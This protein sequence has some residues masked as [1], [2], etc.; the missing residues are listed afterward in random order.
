MD[1]TYSLYYEESS[2]DLF[3]GTSYDLSKRLQRTGEKVVGGGNGSWILSKPAVRFIDEIINGAIARRACPNNYLYN[4][5]GLRRITRKACERLIEELN[6]GKLDF[7]E[8]L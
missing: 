6:S 8:L 4:T 2:T 3:Q 1:K 7:S 5:R